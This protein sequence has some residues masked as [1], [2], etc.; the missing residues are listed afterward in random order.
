L[1]ES[2]SEAL[3]DELRDLACRPPRVHYHRWTRGDVVVWD[4]RS[5]MHRAC[6]WDMREPRTMYHS[7]IAGDPIAE[8]AAAVAA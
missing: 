8:F 2:E 6:P 4:N 1:E 5:L 3:L 7:R